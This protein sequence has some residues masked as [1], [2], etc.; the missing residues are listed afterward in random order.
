[1]AD[2]RLPLDNARAA[3]LLPDLPSIR[4][5]IGAAAF[6]L[7]EELIE[8]NPALAAPHGAQDWT[9]AQ[10]A[11]DAVFDIH[12]ECP[13]WEWLSKMFDTPKRIP[14]LL[15]AAREIELGRTGECLEAIAR[16]FLLDPDALVS[17][18]VSDPEE[19]A[20]LADHQMSTRGWRDRWRIR[21]DLR[22]LDV[23]RCATW[24]LSNEG[25]LVFNRRVFDFALRRLDQLIA[26]EAQ[27][28]LEVP[29]IDSRRE[30]GFTR[31]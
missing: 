1:M 29:A 11:I 31:P 8:K 21:R 6:G 12:N 20:R 19:A 5:E 2:L 27:P 28:R 7:Y 10:K 18:Y 23:R 15:W 17:A 22:S 9:P 16:G 30:N 26:V 13:P 25:Q 24:W 14:R 3:G 4:A